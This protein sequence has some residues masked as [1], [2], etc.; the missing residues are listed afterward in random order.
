MTLTSPDPTSR[1]TLPLKIAA[2]SERGA[3]STGAAP[4]VAAV[5]GAKTSS[6]LLPLMRPISL[7][8]V[9]C[10]ICSHFGDAPFFFKCVVRPDA[11]QSA[12]KKPSRMTGRKV[13]L[14]CPAKL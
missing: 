1:V 9:V 4:P 12:Q 5:V 6:E 10:A 8:E 3:G 14:A 7:A 11:A 13:L 2:R